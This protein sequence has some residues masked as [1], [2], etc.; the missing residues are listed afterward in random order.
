MSALIDNALAQSAGMFGRQTLAT[1]EADDDGN[2]R[3]EFLLGVEAAQEAV[4]AIREG[5]NPYFASVVIMAAGGTGSA[6]IL[7]GFGVGLQR[8]I[9]GVAA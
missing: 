5:A 7:H 3:P 9:R 6:S 4:A 1:V 2:A 8:A